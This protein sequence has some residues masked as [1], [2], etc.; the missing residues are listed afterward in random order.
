MKEPTFVTN[1][2]GTKTAVNQVGFAGINLGRVDIIFEPSTGKKNMLASTYEINNS[3][4]ASQ[5]V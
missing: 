3:I 2:K 1:L 4:E 5:L